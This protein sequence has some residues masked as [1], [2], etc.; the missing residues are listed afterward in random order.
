MEIKFI[1]N[2]ISFEKNEENEYI[3]VGFS[4]E[5]NEWTNYVLLNRSFSNDSQDVDL[6]I[7]GAYIEVNDQ[8]SSGYDICKKAILKNNSF[9]LILH[10]EDEEIRIIIDIQNINLEKKSIEYLKFILG[11]KLESRFN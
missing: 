8:A 5:E 6:G 7:D 3:H 10:L 2:Y 4:D 11:D 1:A 9:E